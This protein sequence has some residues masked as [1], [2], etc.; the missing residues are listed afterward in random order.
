MH[1]EVEA[2]DQATRHLVCPVLALLRRLAVH[3]GDSGDRLKPSVRTAPFP[4]KGALGGC[5]LLS[6]SFAVSRVG[7]VFARGFG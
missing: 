7:D 4:G 1:D 6:L 2:I 3:G 5:E